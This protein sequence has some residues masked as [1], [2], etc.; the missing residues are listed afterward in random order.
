MFNTMTL[1]KAAGALVGSLLFLLLAVWMA[2]GIFD[3][4]VAKNADGETPQAYVIEV[5]DA[6][7]AAEAEEE[8]VDMDALMAN[9]DAAKGEKDFGKCKAC[10][11]LDGSNTTGPHLDGVVGRAIA[12][13]DGF[14]YSNAMVEHAEDYPD[15]SPE[16]LL[17]FLTN[18]RAEVPGTKM[19]FA[20]FKNPQDIANLVAYL[21]Q[22]P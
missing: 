6:A 4:T 14:A 2:S 7:P 22:N 3:M 16:A 5:A 9:A 17:H 20:G 13:V 21:E 12:S 10:H 1:T 11:R 19:V 8:E 18:P 15:W